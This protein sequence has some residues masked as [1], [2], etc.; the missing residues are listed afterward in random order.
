MCVC[1]CVCVCV[2]ARA[3]ACLMY[4]TVQCHTHLK[5]LWFLCVCVW[6]GGLSVWCFVC[7][8]LVGPCSKCVQNIILN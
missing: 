8:V 2:Y 6:E 5:S 1:V 4:D 3:R 7:V